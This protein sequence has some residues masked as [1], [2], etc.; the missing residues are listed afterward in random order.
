MP[1]TV[2]SDLT[3]QTRAKFSIVR[4]VRSLGTPSQSAFTDQLI[5]TS[6][7]FHG[8]WIFKHGTS[9]VDKT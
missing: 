4:K 9:L 5:Q 1:N 2:G 8:R 7:S 3:H 6:E